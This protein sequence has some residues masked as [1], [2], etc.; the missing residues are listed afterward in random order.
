M[1]HEAERTAERYATW[2]PTLID[3]AAQSLSVGF[4]GTIHSTFSLLSAKRVEAWNDG[5]T[6][7]VSRPRGHQVQIN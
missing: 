5:V 1:D 3:K 2:Y 7:I 6:G 4:A